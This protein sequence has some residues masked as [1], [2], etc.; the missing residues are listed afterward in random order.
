[1]N[2]TAPKGSILA[3]LSDSALA[4]IIANLIRLAVAATVPSFSHAYS[5]LRNYLF[6]GGGLCPVTFGR[7]RLGCGRESLESLEGRCNP[8][9]S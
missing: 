6:G 9:L 4:L 3:T 7:R 2:D 5:F 1:M 8:G